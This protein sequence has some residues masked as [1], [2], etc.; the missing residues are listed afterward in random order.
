LNGEL[1]IDLALV[2]FDDADFK[3]EKEVG[4]GFG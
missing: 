4:A 3:T 1:A 2:P